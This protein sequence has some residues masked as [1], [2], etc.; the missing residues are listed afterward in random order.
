[1]L[2][3]GMGPQTRAVV[4]FE[5]KPGTVLELLLECGH[6]TRRR[7]YICQPQRVLCRECAA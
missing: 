3:S 4:S 2:Q 6:V 1:M 7:V 5:A